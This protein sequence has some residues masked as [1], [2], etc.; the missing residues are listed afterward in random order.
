M[1]NG[2]Y[3]NNSLALLSL[4]IKIKSLT[5]ILHINVYNLFLEY[6]SNN[7]IEDKYILKSVLDHFNLRN[8][9]LPGVNLMKLQE[10][11]TKGLKVRIN[12]DN[13]IIV[14]PLTL[15]Y[16]HYDYWLT[17]EYETKIYTKKVR[18]IESVYVLE[19]SSYDCVTNIHP[20]KFEVDLSIWPQF[21]KQ[22]SIKQILECKNGKVIVLVSCTELDSYYIAYQL[23]PLARML[24][25]QA[26]IDSFINRGSATL[27]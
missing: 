21:K 5:P 22:F 11:I 18:E 25:P 15:M 4:L 19:A 17:Y 23:A 26:Y 27:N 10:S 2:S 8:E 7:R 13:K 14:K 6:I 3:S 12:L 20:V 9:Q 24:S 16:M 1:S